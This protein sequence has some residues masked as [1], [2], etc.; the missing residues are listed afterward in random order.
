M[1][2]GEGPTKRQ[3]KGGEREVRKKTGSKSGPVCKCKPSKK[4]KWIMDSSV[5][6]GSA[7]NTILLRPSSVQNGQFSKGGHF[8]ISTSFLPSVVTLLHFT[9]LHFINLT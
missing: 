2:G 6:P 4:K 8:P 1:G 5:R 3:K 9:S 7:R